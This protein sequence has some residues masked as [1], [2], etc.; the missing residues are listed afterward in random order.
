[1][2]SNSA[3]PAPD[4]PTEAE[5]RAFAHEIYIRSGWLPGRDLENWLEAE[6]ILTAERQ[7]QAQHAPRPHPAPAAPARAHVHAHSAAR[8]HA[9]ALAHA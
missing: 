3:H 7:L 4:R 9:H 6:A 1:M 5:I 8:H 2:K